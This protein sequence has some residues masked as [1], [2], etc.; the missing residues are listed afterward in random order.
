MI[1]NIIFLI[2]DK[3]NLLMTYIAAYFKSP[4]ICYLSILIALKRYNF[5]TKRKKKKIF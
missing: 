4:F 3:L 5:F 2:F 1:K